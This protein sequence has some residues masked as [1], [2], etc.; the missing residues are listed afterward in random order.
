MK[1]HSTPS[2]SPMEGAFITREGRWRENRFVLRAKGPKRG[3]LLD[4]P[5]ITSHRRSKL[6]M[7]LRFFRC[8]FHKAYHQLT[9]KIVFSNY[10]NYAKL[11]STY[12]NLADCTCRQSEP[13]YS[14]N[15]AYA[16]KH[17]SDNCQGAFPF[18]FDIWKIL[19][20]RVHLCLSDGRQ[21]ALKVG[22][23]E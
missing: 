6:C 16:R 15:Q 8:N 18:L 2:A 13:K 3:C 23:V 7:Q 1:Q 21:Y 5:R 11:Q 20:H 17:H 22:R 12:S 10:G 4:S 19:V 9:A 14:N